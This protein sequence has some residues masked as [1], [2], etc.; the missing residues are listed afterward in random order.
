MVM[1]MM[2]MRRRMM[3]TWNKINIYIIVRLHFICTSFS[4]VTLIRKITYD[5]K[6]TQYTFHFI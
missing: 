5:K 6:S 3:E 1:M 2:M 4:I